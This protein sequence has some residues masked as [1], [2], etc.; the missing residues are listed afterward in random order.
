MG[1]WFSPQ[2]LS[3]VKFEYTKGSVSTLS[4]SKFEF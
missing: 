4:L 2:T 3:V 1:M